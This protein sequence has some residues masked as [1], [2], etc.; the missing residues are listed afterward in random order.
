[1]ESVVRRFEDLLPDSLEAFVVESDWTWL[2]DRASLTGRLVERFEA[3]RLSESFFPL[4]GGIGFDAWVTDTDAGAALLEQPRVLPIED[5]IRLEGRFRSDPWR[6]ILR[7]AHGAGVITYGGG[8]Q[9]TDRV[10]QLVTIEEP[11]ITISLRADPRT[12]LPR[13]VT[14]RRS[15]SER[16]VEYR[17]FDY[18]ER[19]GG[20]YPKRIERFEGIR[21]TSVRQVRDVRRG[22]RLA[23]AEGLR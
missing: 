22:A 13:R 21:R 12:G 14:V 20:R 11:G 1:M 17:Y 16:E 23:T 4:D 8:I 6:L 5:R 10:F 9:E 18:G 7:V 19:L 2:R 15:D 3:D